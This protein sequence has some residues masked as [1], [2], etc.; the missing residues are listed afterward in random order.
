MDDLKDNN[1]LDRFYIENPYWPASSEDL[2]T[3]NWDTI[4]HYEKPKNNSNAINVRNSIYNF[5][6]SKDCCL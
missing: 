1:E 3:L 6:G 2:E 4:Y 5:L